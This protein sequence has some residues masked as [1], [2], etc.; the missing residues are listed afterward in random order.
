MESPRVG[1]GGQAEQPAAGRWWG[2]G[3]VLT[4]EI[5]LNL[6]SPHSP[7]PRGEPRGLERSAAVHHRTVH[8]DTEQSAGLDGK[9]AFLLAK[10]LVSGKG[11]KGN[12]LFH[13]LGIFIFTLLGR[14]G[15]DQGKRGCG[16]VLRN[17]SNG[18]EQR[19]EV[20]TSSQ[21]GSQPAF[22]AL[23]RS[24]QAFCLQ[25]TEGRR[26]L[27]LEVSLLPFVSGIKNCETFT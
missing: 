3:E 18:K 16:V 13:L 20:V 22:W 8:H 19:S 14:R 9:R 23:L 12:M 4:E 27:E 11:D 21:A 5:D 7:F 26:L 25:R 24:H 17:N 1:L 15:K 10:H 6:M 2:S